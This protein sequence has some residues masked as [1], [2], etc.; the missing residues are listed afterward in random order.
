MTLQLSSYIK[1][2]EKW[3]G[4]AGKFLSLFSLIKYTVYPILDIRD[5]Q[6]VHMW[7]LQWT[8]AAY[9]YKW[10]ID[11]E[12]L[13]GSILRIPGI[14]A[15]LFHNVRNMIIFPFSFDIICT[16]LL[17]PHLLFYLLH[18]LNPFQLV[19]TRI[20]FSWRY[21][22]FSLHTVVYPVATYKIFFR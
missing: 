9:K 15:L 7:F 1:A 22:C 20:R 13:M 2:T 16:K 19:M 14:L 4:L 21:S 10:T 12:G 5:P 17:G 11:N 6:R 18:I 8:P 3:I